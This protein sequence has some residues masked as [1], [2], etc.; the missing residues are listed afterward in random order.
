[1]R[2]SLTLSCPTRFLGTTCPGQP[3]GR[4]REEGG[5]PV[6]DHAGERG[7]PVLRAR[8]VVRLQKTALPGGAV[9]LLAE[10]VVSRLA[11]RLQSGAERAA[12]AA[13]VPIDDFCR[14]LIAQD[15]EAALGMIRQER[16]EGMAL[17]TIYAG[18][19][20]AAAE[21]LGE[22]WNEDRVGFLEM[23]LAA[24]RIFG[25]MRHLRRTIPVPHH[26][27]GP[28]RQALFATVPGDLHTMGVTMAADL[29]RNRGWEIDLR[30]GY[31]HEELMEAVA[32]R[33]Y[34]VIGLSAG[35]MAGVLPLARCVVA[36]RITHPEVPVFVGGSVV[37]EMPGIGALV[38]ADGVARDWDET[39]RVVTELADRG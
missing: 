38:G 6:T 19:L 18:T 2:A 25:I 31:G 39:V 20:A 32:G 9:Q 17:E 16:L 7:G 13:S 29:F 37:G 8:D 14:A 15:A 21:R 27:V 33:S 1:M 36:F 11:S 24:G 12:I 26:P 3:P 10:E 5:E 23:S 30:V 4:L 35:G 28:E 34:R 22:W